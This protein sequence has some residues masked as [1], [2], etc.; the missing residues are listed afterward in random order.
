MAATHDNLFIAKFL[1]VEV[2]HVEKWVKEYPTPY[3]VEE[4]KADVTH[5]A[6]YDVDLHETEILFNV[7][8]EELS[9]VAKAQID[10]WCEARMGI[11]CGYNVEMF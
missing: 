4:V 9:V 1:N 6:L 3:Q 8:D 11:D 10:A 2:E 5:S 7:P